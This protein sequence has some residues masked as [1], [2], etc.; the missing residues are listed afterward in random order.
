MFSHIHKNS[1]V[2]LSV[3]ADEGS[4][5]LNSDRVRVNQI[6]VNLLTN[7][8]KFTESGS[9]QLGYKI[10]E[11]NEIYYFVS[12]SGIGI[13]PEYH[14]VIFDRFR[15][16]NTDDHKIHRGTGLGLAISRKLVELLGGRIWINSEPGKGSTFYFTLAN[17]VIRKIQA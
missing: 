5:F 17:S 1:N 14:Q 15:K 16:L 11:T 7:A 6:F 12:D 8:F 9:I 3:A 2:K 10:S 13:K 4:L